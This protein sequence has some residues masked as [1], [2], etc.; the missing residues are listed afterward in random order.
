MLFHCLSSSLSPCSS[1]NSAPQMIWCYECDSNKD[2]RCGDP[3]NITAIQSDLPDLKQCQGCCVK[4]VMHKNTRKLMRDNN[5]FFF[6]SLSLSP[7]ITPTY[8]HVHL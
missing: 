4:I 6:S 7:L 2:P 8:L 3:F 5:F 1:T